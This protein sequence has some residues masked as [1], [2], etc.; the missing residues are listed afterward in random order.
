[1]KPQFIA[2][3]GYCENTPPATR[4]V[5]LDTTSHTVPMVCWGFPDDHLVLEPSAALL[6]AKKLI[7]SAWDGMRETREP[8]AEDT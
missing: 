3:G 1:M 2:G 5:W 8:E 4:Q 6:L 7:R